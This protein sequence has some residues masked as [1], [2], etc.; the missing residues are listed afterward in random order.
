MIFLTLWSAEGIVGVQYAIPYE[1][2][3]GKEFNE[4]MQR[5]Q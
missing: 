1:T 4:A 5:K 3:L 2:D